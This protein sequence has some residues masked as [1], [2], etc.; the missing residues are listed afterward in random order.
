MELLIGKP[1]NPLELFRHD[2][3]GKLIWLLMSVKSVSNV[4]YFRYIFGIFPT[5]GTEDTTFF[6]LPK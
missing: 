4:V 5:F 2:V 6:L 1:E 3:D